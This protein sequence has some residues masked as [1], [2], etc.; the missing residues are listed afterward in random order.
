[1]ETIEPVRF[2]VE[3]RGFDIDEN[4]APRLTGFQS[5]WDETHDFLFNNIIGGYFDEGSYRRQ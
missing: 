3:G 2:S 5:D 1:M 4:Y